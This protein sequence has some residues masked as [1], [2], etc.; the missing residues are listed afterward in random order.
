MR[1]WLLKTEPGVFS[2][3]DLL[4]APDQT[5]GWGGIRNYQARNFLRDQ[6][7]EG[8]RVLIYHSSADPPAVA[9]L[10]EVVRAG[11]PDPTQFDP[12]D[13]H[14]DPE[15]TP[16]APRWYQV[17]VKAVR[18]LSRAVSLEEIRRT[19]A[20]AKMPLVQRG[21]RLSVQPVAPEEYAL[22]VRMGSK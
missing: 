12:K 18:K 4:Q 17:D 15:S 6:M 16:A 13:D 22:I 11:Y 19:K 3:D 1:H 2:F 7:E 9:G 5:T 14:Y 8:D 21:Q 20:L 10:A